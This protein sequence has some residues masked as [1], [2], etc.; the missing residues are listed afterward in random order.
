MYEIAPRDLDHF[1]PLTKSPADT[2]EDEDEEEEDSDD[3]E[4]DNDKDVFPG[5]GG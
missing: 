3:A 4:E 2:N 1:S 5:V